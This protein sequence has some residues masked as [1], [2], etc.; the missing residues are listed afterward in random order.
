MP[1]E[2]QNAAS[3]ND[4]LTWCLARAPLPN[5]RTHGDASPFVDEAWA[6]QAERRSKRLWIAAAHLQRPRRPRTRTPAA[7]ACARTEPRW[8][9][10]GF[11]PVDAEHP[12]LGSGTF[13]AEHCGLEA[14]NIPAVWNSVLRRENNYAEEPRMVVCVMI[15][16]QM[17]DMLKLELTKHMSGGS[18]CS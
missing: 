2:S 14:D 7:A 1:F 5:R 9:W 3:E 4:Q 16:Q 18:F 12:L 8:H 6:A 15:F 11:P 17:V 13:L 10:S